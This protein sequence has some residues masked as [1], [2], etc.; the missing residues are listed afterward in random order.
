[1]L[2]Q[3]HRFRDPVYRD[4][5]E[6]LRDHQPAAAVEVL[7]VQGAVSDHHATS[8]EAAWTAMV[9]DWLTLRDGGG[10]VLMLATER[11]TVAEVNQLA[12]ARLVT[13]GQV[14]RRARTYQAP[15]DHRAIVLAVGEQVILRRN[16]RIAQPDGAT[17][18]MRNG[19]TARITVTR[20]RGITIEL[21]AAHRAPGD[22]AA[23]TLP[24]GYV[25][26][27]VEY[28]YART[29]DTAQGVTVDHCLF[30]PSTRSSAERGY[31][32]LSR[33]RLTNRVYATVDH[34]WIDALG[35]NRNYALATDQSREIDHALH[36]AVR[37]R[38]STREH[39]RHTPLE[40][41]L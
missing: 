20:R 34:G 33:G 16:Q 30:A 31:V 6:L 29:V 21:D 38:D 27:H 15:D 32:A 24:A 17:V 18:A 19:M 36:R 5:A 14:A 12:R 39:D 22:A 40:L 26:A 37:R 10:D 11:T 7:R 28:G 8:V 23:I 35:C 9:D 2:G 25:G 13:H 3:N 4:A 1:M 41:G